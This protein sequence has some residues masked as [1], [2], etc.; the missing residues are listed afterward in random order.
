MIASGLGN[1]FQ[2]DIRRFR[3]PNPVLAASTSCIQKIGPDGGNVI[4]VQGQ[5]PFITDR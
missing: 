1:I 5:V 3:K 4:G 2:L